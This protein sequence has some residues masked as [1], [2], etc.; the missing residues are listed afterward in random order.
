MNNLISI[1]TN[2]LYSKN[3]KEKETDQDEFIKHNELIF[4]L[5]KP[6]YTY[7]NQRQIVREKKI[8]EL[9]FTVSEEQIEAK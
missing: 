5:E 7:S 4:L 2:I 3:Q 8:E 9:R 6:N 1:R